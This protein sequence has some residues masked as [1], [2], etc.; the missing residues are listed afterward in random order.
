MAIVPP[1]PVKMSI[2]STPAHLP[3]VRAALEHFCLLIGFD[4][5]GAGG[6]VMAVDEALANII[7]HAYGFRADEQIEVT[8]TALTE[9]ERQTGVEVVLVD[10]G[11]P[12]TAQSI[13]GRDLGDVRP[14]GLGSHIIDTCMDSVEYTPC[15]PIGTRLRMVKYL[16]ADEPK[17]KSSVVGEQS[18]E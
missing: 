10:G 14:G 4:D 11:R 9:G 1:K 13:R 16:S 18:E 17:G 8:L 3:V 6:V 5:A 15:Q 7:E 12:T 2:A